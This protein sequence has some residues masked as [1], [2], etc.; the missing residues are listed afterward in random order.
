MRNVAIESLLVRLSC[1]IWQEVA[2]M[3]AG[4]VRS[5]RGK[6][7]PDV[8]RRIGLQVKRI[9]MAE[10][11]REE[12]DDEGDIFFGFC[13]ESVLPAQDMG[14]RHSEESCSSD[15]KN[16]PSGPDCSRT[17]LATCRFVVVFSARH[18]DPPTSCSRE[19]ARDAR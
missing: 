5:N 4:N 16:S 15:L 18:L 6:L 10:A 3:N 12:N 1:E 9:E 17:G 7:P 11:A 8:R 19:C 13:A 2:N 14:E